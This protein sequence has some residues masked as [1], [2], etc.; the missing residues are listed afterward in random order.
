M[1]DDALG[2]DRVDELIAQGSAMDDDQA[3]E[4]ARRALDDAFGG[5]GDDG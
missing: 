5:E 4:L 1:L 2:S 3:V